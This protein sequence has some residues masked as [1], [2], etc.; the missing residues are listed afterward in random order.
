MQLIGKAK[1]EFSFL[2]EDYNFR[3]H[4]EFNEWPREQGVSYA[5]NSREVYVGW[6]VT[7]LPYITV[8]SLVH[9][10]YGLDIEDV[11]PRSWQ[12][13]E[14]GLDIKDFPMHE[15][16]LDQSGCLLFPPTWPASSDVE[17]DEKCRALER[18]AS[19]FRQRCRSYDWLRSANT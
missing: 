8:G 10:P 15:K 9:Q 14:E 12:G 1:R 4:F 6:S 5:K 3:V 17:E 18:L 13:E 16:A 19:V 2:V 11:I 7:R